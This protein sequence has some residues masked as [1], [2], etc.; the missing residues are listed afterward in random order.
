VPVVDVLPAGGAATVDVTLDL[1]DAS[2]FDVTIPFS[3]G[4]GRTRG[5]IVSRGGR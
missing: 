2:G 5:M 3:A 1:A 4:G